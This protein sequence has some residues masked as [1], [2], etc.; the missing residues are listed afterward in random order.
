MLCDLDF[1]TRLEC[2]GLAI[3]V[4]PN[5]WL[6]FVFFS[7]MTSHANSCRIPLLKFFLAIRQNVRPTGHIRLR[8]LK[9]GE[10]IFDT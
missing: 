2:P 9:A 3:G 5:V 1:I 4:E 7:F 8:I 6:H 10:Y